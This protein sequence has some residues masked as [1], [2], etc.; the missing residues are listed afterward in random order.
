M[1]SLCSWTVYCIAR[2]TGKPKPNKQ[3]LFFL[4]E[5]SLHRYEYLHPGVIKLKR[6][7]NGVGACGLEAIMHLTQ[8]SLFEH[9]E[10]R[11]YA[12][13]I[14]VSLSLGVLSFGG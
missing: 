5:R 4:L 1:G 13:Y 9:F 7:K 8:F 6:T 12:Q 14:N 10:F 3:Q 11:Y 2:S